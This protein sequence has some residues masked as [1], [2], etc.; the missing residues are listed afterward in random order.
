VSNFPNPSPSGHLLA[1]GA[2][3]LIG[4][5]LLQR[6]NRADLTGQAAL[7]TGGSRGLGLELA[8]ELGAHGCKLA[9]CARDRAELDRAAAE[10]GDAGYD[11]FAE[12]CDVS[13][14]DAVTAFV[15]NVEAHYGQIDL[16]ITNAGEM[17]VG[18][19][20]E[21]SVADFERIMSIDFFGTLYPI[22]AV[23]PG[24]RARKAGRVALITSIGG[25]IAT[26]HLLTYDAAKFATVGLG[27]GL[28]AE[29]SRDGIVVTTVVPGLMRTGSH[30]Q[31]RFTGGE[32]QR[33]ADFAWFAT[34]ASAPTSPPADKAARTVVDAI[35]RGK[36][37]VTFP[38]PFALVSRLHGL[39]PGTTIRV[40]QMAEALLPNRPPS[41]GETVA[42]EQ[43]EPIKERSDST[44]LHVVTKLGRDA[45]IDFSQT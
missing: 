30:I 28:A 11:V 16:L 3:G 36:L 7:I 31:A 35:R 19:V 43:G 24:M 33:E 42:T 32:E 18:P 10:L 26:P 4:L 13:D 9:I 27:E 22:M 1:L 14:N 44:T 2:G 5:K 8:R 29:L 41:P 12:V 20:H 21:L 37:E 17:Q 40:M 23:L 38:W 45:E 25:R 34:G 6:R 39:A 15:R